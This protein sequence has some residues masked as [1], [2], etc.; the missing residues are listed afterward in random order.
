MFQF[1]Y[2][3]APTRGSKPQTSTHKERGEKEPGTEPREGRSS[4]GRPRWPEPQHMNF[5]RFFSGSREINANHF[6]SSDRSV[7]EA[8]FYQATHFAGR[9]ARDGHLHGLPVPAPRLRS[10]SVLPQPPGG[11]PSADGVELHLLLAAFLAAEGGVPS[12]H[13][14]VAVARQRLGAE[15]AR[16]QRRHGGLAERLGVEEEGAGH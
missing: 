8:K 2:G 9:S 16:V 10:G 5:L 11:L 15:R 12:V 13:E 4:S 3:A 6:I 7:I 14:D 1:T